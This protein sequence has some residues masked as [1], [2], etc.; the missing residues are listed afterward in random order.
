MGE[1]AGGGL[2]QD[3]VIFKHKIS[4]LSWVSSQLGEEAETFPKRIACDARHTSRAPNCSRKFSAVDVARSKSGE[5][6]K[7]GHRPSKNS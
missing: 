1:G 2:T 6:S 3:V 4:H 5:L 7:D